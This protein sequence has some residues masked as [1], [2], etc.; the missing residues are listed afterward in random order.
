M[1]KFIVLMCLVV[2]GAICGCGKASYEDTLLLGHH[3]GEKEED[4]YVE[5]GENYRVSEGGELFGRSVEGV[6]GRFGDTKGLCKMGYN[7]PLANEEAV[8][9]L[10]ANVFELLADEEVLQHSTDAK[11]EFVE[12]SIHDAPAGVTLRKSKE[13][14]FFNVEIWCYNDTYAF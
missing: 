6:D 8:D 13:G 10:I 4:F 12:W 3:W 1:R 5:Q 14:S 2:C 9:E 11:G 7:I